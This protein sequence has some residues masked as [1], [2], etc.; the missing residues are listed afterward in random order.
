MVDNYQFSKANY[1]QGLDKESPYVKKDWNYINDINSGVYTNN[2]QTLIQ[3]DLS[4][5][6]NSSCM[7]NISEA[8]MAIPITYISAWSSN[9]AGN[10]LIAPNT[11]SWASTGLKSGYF[12]LVH[13]ADI[14]CDGKQM[15]QYQP[16]LN[17]YVSFKLLSQMSQDNLKTLGTTLGMGEII[18][19]AQ[20]LR[21]AGAATTVSTTAFPSAVPT[22]G[23]GG[24]GIS[25]NTPFPIVA[26]ADFGDQPAQG[27]EFTNTY[28][29][30]YYSRL[31]CIPDVSSATSQASLLFGNA[32]A[33]STT[34][35]SNVTNLAKEMKPY[36]TILNAN[37]AVWYDVAIIRLQDLFD[38][39]GKFPLTSRFNGN[40]RLYINTG[41]V[42][43]N[44]GA[45]GIMMTSASGI[46]F[47]GTCPLLQ[48]SLGTFP[49]NAGAIVSGL[50]VGQNVPNTALSCGGGAFTTTINFGNAQAS[51]FMNACR[52]Y[53]PQITLKAEIQRNYLSENRN[54]KIVYTSFYTNIINSV[55]ANAT[56]SALIQSGVSNIRGVLI[57]PFLSASTNGVP[58]TNA[59]AITSFSQYLSPFD[60]A[61]MTSAPISLLNFNVMIGGT[62]VLANQQNFGWELFIE[63]V[64]LY[65]K[66]NAADLG[67]S[68][69]LINQFYYENA[70][71]PYY[72]DCT[73]GQISDQ[74]TPRNVNI[75]FTNNSL[76]TI[77][78][79]V[80]TEYFKEIV[81]DVETGLITV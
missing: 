23:V 69:G 34:V 32:T 75:T 30:G 6:Y 52:L 3:F 59:S 70:Y 14:S 2:G 72:V 8:Y 10:T 44:I 77:D 20:S 16:Y 36:F 12:Q 42:I 17:A 45:N 76:Q 46:T 58:L 13:A 48:S 60:T 54:K 62:N 81:I 78:C 7:T 39:F 57:I 66:I 43:S 47:T 74:L 9:A 80:F 15:E 40:L 35:I 24:N 19:N 71:R 61:P 31:K 67:F 25:N 5:I 64:S 50:Y 41:S 21:F 33:T 26:G 51:H 49:T 63:Q 56:Y 27:T 11:S 53:Y 68:C 73:R 55:A 65:E 28:N 29:E 38:S 79:L 1:V 4:S 37:Y 18:D 22:G